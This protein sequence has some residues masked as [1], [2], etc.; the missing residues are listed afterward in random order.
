MPFSPWGSVRTLRGI[1]GTPVARCSQAHHQ[2]RRKA[3][4]RPTTANTCDR[5][6]LDP[7]SLQRSGPLASAPLTRRLRPASP[8][9]RITRFAPGVTLAGE[10]PLP[11]TWHSRRRR[12]SP[13]SV[14]VGLEQA[15]IPLRIVLAPL[16]PSPHIPSVASIASLIRA[17]RLPH[18]RRE[19]L[20]R[21]ALR[22][23][24]VKMGPRFIK[25]RPRPHGR[26]GRLGTWKTEDR[27]SR[28]I[29]EPEERRHLISASRAN[30]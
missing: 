21:Q 23:H 19:T 3:L 11:I 16:M 20:T 30:S 4:Q 14:R 29:I 1:K 7:S 9:L 15:P 25:R 24:C 6:T 2:S 26:P 10:L 18:R 13:A 12:L 17:Q 8:K 5:R 27:I 22:L 28:Q